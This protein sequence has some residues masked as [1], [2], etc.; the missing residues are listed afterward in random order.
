MKRAAALLTLLLFASQA[1]AWMYTPGLLG[2]LRFEDP[3]WKLNST[4]SSY[5]VVNPVSDFPTTEIT[6]G[7]FTPTPSGQRES[8]PA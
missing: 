3:G 4:G 7:S 6:G 8:S 5:A 2:Y 1:Q